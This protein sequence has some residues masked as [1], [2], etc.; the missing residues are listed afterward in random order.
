MYKTP[1]TGNRMESSIRDYLS[2]PQAPAWQKLFLSRWVPPG[3]GKLI[4][5]SDPAISAAGETKKMYYKFAFTSN[6]RGWQAIKDIKDIK[7]ITGSKVLDI[8][9]AYGGFLVAAIRAGASSARGIEINRHLASI[10]ENNIED[11]SISDFAAVTIGD[12]LDDK[13]TESLGKF[14]IIICNDVIEHVHDA[15]LLV[16][17]I[18]KLLSPGGIA[19]LEIPNKRAST[20]LHKDG[21]YSLFAITTLPHKIAKEYYALWF[22]GKNYE[23]SMG[24]YYDIEEYLDWFNQ[25]GGQSQFLSAWR[26]VNALEITRKGYAEFAE[27]LKSKK[28]ENIP[29]NLWETIKYYSSEF[30]RAYENDHQLFMNGGIDIDTF[31]R[32]Y[33]DT[34]WRVVITQP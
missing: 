12:A 26:P 8:G 27:K 13:L 22:E 9:C 19:Y 14:D 15:R 33:N 3:I 18:S 1:M 25:E 16:K 11:H 2:L 7:T 17:N 28:P 20:F 5:T 29:E 6:I 24:E 21:H 30:C 4:F 34:F 31:L 32:R 23:D 10:A